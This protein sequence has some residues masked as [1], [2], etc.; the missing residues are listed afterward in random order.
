MKV[1]IWMLKLIFCCCCWPRQYL[2]VCWGAELLFSTLKIGS[3][4]RCYHQGKKILH[5]HSFASFFLYLMLLCGNIVSLDVIYVQ[6]SVMQ[7]VFILWVYE[8]VLCICLS[9][10]MHVR[11]RAHL[12]AMNQTFLICKWWFKISWLDNNT[13]H[14]K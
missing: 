13:N 12:N 4:P 11:M 14:I 1:R 7:L 8:Y 6:I 2:Y 10:C 9:V 3:H 5:I